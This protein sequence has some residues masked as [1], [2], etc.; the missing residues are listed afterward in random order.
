MPN[1]QETIT[2]PPAS[3]SSSDLSSGEVDQTTFSWRVLKL[4][5][6]KTKKSWTDSNLASLKAMLR[7]IWG[8]MRT[9][10]I[11]LDELQSAKP[12]DLARLFLKLLEKNEEW[13]LGY[14]DAEIISNF[15]V[16]LFDLIERNLCLEGKEHQCKALSKEFKGIYWMRFGPRGRADLQQLARKTNQLFTQD[17]LNAACESEG[18]T[19]R[20]IIQFHQLISCVNEPLTLDVQVLRDYS[21]PEVAA[22][23]LLKSVPFF[24]DDEHSANNIITL[25][26]EL[27]LRVQTSESFDG[28][29]EEAD[30]YLSKADLVGLNKVNNT[31]RAYLSS[32]AGQEDVCKERISKL[33]A[34]VADHLEFFQGCSQE[35][36]VG[37]PGFFRVSPSVQTGLNKLTASV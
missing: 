26:I 29:L 8:G 34:K 17:L 14:N 24:S 16:F 21:S 23:A 31:L 12:K 22:L 37:S 6:K 3:S 20:K 4:V 36:G 11:N 33:E 9:A 5:P 28:L 35:R 30:I 2:P 10:G 1:R 32:P 15:E 27:M 19:P 13:G 25:S 7:P 18:F